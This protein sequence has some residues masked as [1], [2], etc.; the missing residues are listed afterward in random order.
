MNEDPAERC[1]LCLQ[2]IDRVLVGRVSADDQPPGPERLEEARRAVR[3]GRR[4]RATAIIAEY[5][6]TTALLASTSRSYKW[7]P[8]VLPTKRIV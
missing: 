6:P 3:R 8:S 7:L 1:A 4:Y 2:I 5:R